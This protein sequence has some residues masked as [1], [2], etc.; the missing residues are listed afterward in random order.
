MAPLAAGAVGV[1]LNVEFDTGETG[2]FGMVEITENAGDLD[3]V[4]TLETS[5]LGRRADLREFY[6][7]LLVDENLEL[8]QTNAP[9]TPYELAEDPSVS[10]GA[11]SNFDYSVNFGNGAGRPGNGVLQVA[12]FTLSGDGSLSIEDLIDSS[13]ASGGSIEVNFAAHVQSTDLFRGADS[14]TVGGIVP[15]PSTGLLVGTGLSL[16]AAGRRRG[17]FRQA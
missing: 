7:N 6:F 11:G 10:G 1:S 17:M 3:F 15:E 9:T 8:L 5:Q 14:E 4:I 16:A 12:S 2:S 13:F